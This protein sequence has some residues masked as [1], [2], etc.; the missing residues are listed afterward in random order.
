M[1]KKRLLI[2]LAV[3]FGFYLVS[4]LYLVIVVFSMKPALGKT[5]TAA[6][7]AM[8]G[9]QEKDLSK[10]TESLNQAET[11]LQQVSRRYNLAG[12]LKVVPGLGIYVADGRH[13]LNAGIAGMAAAKS[14]ACD[15]APCP[16]QPSWE[17]VRRS[18][19]PRGFATRNAMN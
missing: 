7:T 3:F 12:W 18:Q 17:W 1:V 5:L 2:G 4:W 6:Q 14:V 15:L 11:Q 10:A 13:G 8:A 19:K 9:L 16:L